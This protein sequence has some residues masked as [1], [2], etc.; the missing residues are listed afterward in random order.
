MNARA[1][2]RE[3]VPAQGEAIRAIPKPL[4]ALIVDDSVVDA[5]LTVCLLEQDGYSVTS[6]RVADAAAFAMALK[7][8][9][10]DVVLSEYAVP[11]LCLP[12]A[13]EQVRAAGLD[14]PFIVVTGVVG[15]ETAVEAMR[16]G[17]SDYVMKGNNRRLSPAI[18]REIREAQS[19]GERRRALDAFSVKDSVFQAS[20]AA[21]S[22][23]NTDGIISEANAAFLRIWGYESID[24]VIG[25]PMLHFLSSQ[26]ESAAVCEALDSRGEWESDFTAKR[27]DG[28]TFVAHGLATVL[29]DEKGRIAGY[30]ATALDITERVRAQEAVQGSEKRFRRLIENVSDVITVLDSSGII[31]YESPAIERVLGYTP[32]ELLGR[33]ALELLHPDDAQA[34]SD[35][36]ERVTSAPGVSASSALRFRHKDGSWRT[37]ESTRR[38]MIDDRGQ[39]MIV[40][41]ARDITERKQAEAEIGRLRRAV[42]SSGEVIFV[43]DR[44]GVITYVNPE[45]TR[46]YGYTAAE[47]VGRATPRI[48][49]SGMAKPQDYEVFWKTLLGGKVD[50][51]EW[52][53]RAKDGRTVEVDGSASPILDDERN[54]VGFLAVQK[55]ITER[56]RSEEAVLRG[57]A[58]S[59]TLLRVAERLTAEI[60]LSAVLNAVCEE[61]AAALKAPT[62]T[63]NLYDEAEGMLRYSGGTGVPPTFVERVQPWRRATFDECIQR[64]GPIVVIPDVQEIPG[65]LNAALYADLNVHT[66]AVVAIRHKGNLVGTANIFTYD[67]VRDFTEDD[68]AL[69]RGLA[70]QASQALVN[71]RLFDESQ[72]RLRQ[73]QALHTIDT[74]I[75]SSLDLRATLNIVLEQVTAQL[76]VDA[77]S[78]LRLNSHLQTL[79][80]AAGKGFRGKGIESSRLRVGEGLAGLAALEGRTVSIPCVSESTVVLAR[81]SLLAGEDF[82][83]YLG[84]PL[85]AKGQV[86]GVLEVFHRSPLRPNEEWRDFLDTLAGQAAIAIEN[87]SLF[88]DLQLSHLELAL[89]YDATIEGWSRAMDL[90]DKETEGHTRRVTE[91]AVDLARAMGYPEAELT[92]LRRGALLHDIGK[93]GVPD[94]ILL[95]PGSLTEEEWVEMR[96]HPAYAYDLLCPIDYLRPALDIP[97]CHHEKWDGTG[98]PRG[99]RGEQIPLAAR[100]FAVLD[101]WD[102]LTSERPYRPAWEPERAIE[103]IRSSSGCDF[104]PKVVEA[105]LM[106]RD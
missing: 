94:P 59:S 70:D 61:T 15:E 4:R 46:L 16:A 35:L 71:A 9:P 81:A 8:G 11:G 69:L 17:A 48:L 62:V 83:S 23:A 5:G 55:D 92:H 95:K 99:L 93:M 1:R 10:W 90:R 66:M 67:Q 26:D 19:R 32:E 25:Q 74:A 96:K 79:E 43:T 87:A 18:D 13:L 82:V 47:V 36:Y 56:K 104:D 40:V 51:G 76:G 86:Q 44:E 27:K 2:M 101:V 54:I 50:K 85:I 63:V 14:I 39:V 31:R 105:F 34:V 52:V 73:T 65:F 20:L 89:A 6:G 75:S 77:A 38:G 28:S 41:N 12:D 106:Q 53:N 37:I 7:G 72:R 60:T 33:S 3:H 57:V 68:L 80:Y 91:L 30:Q 100:I 78:I 97:Y 24:E 88:K 98:Y 84:A 49:N 42:E 21:N 102:A 45:F 29:R 58:R 64:V 22:I 103:H